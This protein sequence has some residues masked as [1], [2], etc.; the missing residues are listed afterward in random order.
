VKFKTDNIGKFISLII[1]KKVDRLCS[2][3][4]ELN[5]CNITFKSSFK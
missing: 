2:A 3:D 4:E 5:N 1:R